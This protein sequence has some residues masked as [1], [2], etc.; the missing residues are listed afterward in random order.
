MTAPRVWP[1]EWVARVGWRIRTLEEEVKELRGHST[2]KIM[3]TKTTKN[4]GEIVL[5]E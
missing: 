5:R 3:D 4:F 2:G 1:W